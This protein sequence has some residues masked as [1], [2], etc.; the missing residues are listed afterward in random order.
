K[1]LVYLGVAVTLVWPCV[2]GAPLARLAF[3]NRPI[4]WMGE[5]SYSV[6]LLHLCILEGVM[7]L[8]GYRL[9]TGSAATAFVVTMGLSILAAALTYRLVERPVMR[10]RRLVPATAPRRRVASSPAAAEARS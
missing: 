7:H 1:N 10:L 4:R 5:I 6:F 3:G 9:F 2:V 8:L